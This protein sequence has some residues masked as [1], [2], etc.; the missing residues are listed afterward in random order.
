MAGDERRGKDGGGAHFATEMRR[1]VGREGHG[2]A[3]RVARLRPRA[4][5][6]SGAG[7]GS[8]RAA[9]L[10]TFGKG[11]RQV[12][13]AED[14][15]MPDQDNAQRDA[16]TPPPV[17]PAPASARGT[18]GNCGSPLLGEYCYA[19]GQPVTGMVRHFSTILGDFT[20]TVLNWDRSEERRVGKECVSTC[21]SRWSPYH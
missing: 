8:W 15:R 13:G 3:M 20:D 11:T 16:A 18:C 19:C 6:A 21:R 9:M 2:E 14:S 12:R 7:A 10:P 17:P 4:D 1:S 5:R